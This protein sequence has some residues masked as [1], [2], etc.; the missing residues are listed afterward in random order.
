MLIAISIII[1]S[2][3][4]YPITKA[5][6][7]TIYVQP[8]ESI[9]DAIDTANPGD[10]VFVYNGT[11]YENLF[12]DKKINLV[13]ENKNTTIIDGGGNDNAVMVYDAYNIT[14]SRF[15]IQNST[16]LVMQGLMI[17][18]ADYNEIF[19]N[20]FKNNYIGVNL[21]NYSNDNIIH[22]N[23]FKNNIYNAI[24][25][26]DWKNQWDDGYPSG[27]NYWDD[28]TGVDNYQGPNQNI[29]GSDGIGDTPYIIHGPLECEDKYP[30]MNYSG[31]NS[32]PNTPYNPTPQNGA[33][34]I[35]IDQDLFWTGGDQDG[36]TVTY[37]IYFGT[38]SSPPKVVSNQ[39]GTSY[40]PGTM[41]YNTKYYWRIIAWDN[42]GESS[43]GSVWD[44]T[45]GD[46][47]NDP[48]NVPSDPNPSTHSTS[49]DLNADLSWTGGDPDAGD[50]VT[51]DIYFGTTSSP[52]KVV[53][54]QS[55]TNYDPGTMN[56][57]TKYYWKI[58]AWDNHGE[59]TNG[60][61]WDFTTGDEPNEPPNTPSNPNPS[62]Y[63][64]NV[65]IDADLSWVGGDP[66]PGDIV[67]YDIYFGTASDPPLKKS[68]HTSTSYDP[69]LMN[70]NTKYY[71]KIT[72]WDNHGD[73][74]TGPIWDF[75]TENSA[76]NTPFNPT[77]PN[78]STSININQ[79]LY[80]DCT[81][82][83]GDPLTY[84]VYFG[85]TNP[86]NTKVSSNQIVSIYDPGTMNY[87]TKYYWKITAW[88]NHGESTNGPI[89]DFTTG[90]EPNDPPNV[91][92]NPNPANHSAGVDLNADLSWT[93]GDPDPEDTV[94]Y[95]IYFGTS[96]S[97]L[98]V[99]SGQAGTSYDPGQMNY[100]TKY[101]WKI[102]AWDNHG[103][104]TSGPIWDFTTKVNN[105]PNT[106]SN[107]IP[108]NHL[109]SVDIDADLNWI[110]GDPDSGDTVTYDIYFGSASSPPK[111]VSNQSGTS[112][113]PDT[114]NYNTKYY[115]K[116]V[117]WDNHEASK[118]GP[119]WDFTTGGD[120][121][122]DPPN[123]PSN[124]NPAN[125]SAGVDLNADLSWISGDP[126]SGDTVTYDIYFG[127]SSN[128]PLY[129]SN[130]DSDS[131]DPGVMISNTTYYWRIVS[132]DNHGASKTGPIWDFTTV[133]FNQPPNTPS[134]PIPSNDLAN[135]DINA[136]LGWTGDDPDND[137]VTYDVYFGTTSPPEIKISNHSSTSYNPGT[138][139]YNTKY[140][141][142]IIA[143]DNHGN[144]STGPIWSFTTGAQ[145]PGGGGPGGGS[146]FI[147]PNK[148]PIAD[149]SASENS[150]L[151]NT[152]VTFNASYSYDE[153]G[154]ITNYTWDFGDSSYG[155]SILTTHI[156]EK[157]G[158]YTV[159]LTV[160]DDKGVSDTD[161]FEII[162][163]QPSNPPTIP[164]IEGPKT[165]KQNVEYNFTVISTDPDNDNIQYVFDWGDYNTTETDFLTN[166]TIFTV[167]HKW[168][169][170]GI[171]K[172]RVVA[173]DSNYKSSASAE[174]NILI[175]II[176]CKNVG[177]FIDENSD[178]IY[179]TFYSNATG[180]LTD[181]IYQDGDYLIDTDGDGIENYNYNIGT[182]ALTKIKTPEEETLEYEDV[183]LY[184]LALLV[185]VILISLIIIAKR[186]KHK[187]EEEKEK[188]KKTKPSTKKSKDQKKRKN[189]QKEEKR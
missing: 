21:K 45:T 58:I 138:M 167:K 50:T 4:F 176:Y 161:S 14:I 60:P 51:Y 41:S 80:W 39:S 160:T 26:T 156:Y 171:Y 168:T 124:P 163:S 140:Y 70:Y 77:P 47:P 175:D 81:D 143:W 172:I 131:Y 89:W 52:P 35:N 165:G 154:E 72:A 148:V 54:N 90:S 1:L 127:T 9:Q 31:I 66:D 149:A 157:M 61:I 6:P 79:D 173:I 105:P 7:T 132:K 93:G 24:D 59:S 188:P 182:D 83:D 178:G 109:T 73:S 15:T 133:F 111:V 177:Y 75:T 166:G 125:H 29:T 27:G 120:E 134:N 23:Y 91:P 25:Y 179:D 88:D 186:P 57:N 169:S 164:Q 104:S 137:P 118:T 126:D 180:L 145:S 37:D 16:G 187:A 183:I 153:D 128:P 162:I 152:A 84:D 62:N 3:G 19:D 44:F 92:S 8:G 48:P 28:Y 151:V 102:T 115:W 110:G 36:D 40:D 97:P 144:S 82:P 107:P 99:I 170:A 13:G 181:L 76:P 53:S 184:I 112:Y 11:Y 116:I 43:V 30:L 150:G 5:D 65:D 56:Y 114:M 174:M 141:W 142:K 85:T 103:A 78:G 117:A 49:I 100:N 135:V 34:S 158:I 18:D 17:W 86:P 38:A 22:H 10:T 68:G 108:S 155:Y 101:Y 95:D 32:P 71:W 94:T 96:S 46:V 146:P 159:K 87:D 139:N 63:L 122:N 67:T 69:G 119:I 106:P 20:I 55:G 185:I 74:T 113:D 64:T 33:T 123:V 189:N 12:I 130:H 136:N 98:L 129:K 147:P 121:P 2:F 42:H